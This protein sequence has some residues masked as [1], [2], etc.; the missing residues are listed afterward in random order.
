M[1]SECVATTRTGARHHDLQAVNVWLPQEQMP[2]TT[3]RKLLDTGAS[4]VA[5]RSRQGMTAS[6]QRSRVP[7]AKLNGGKREPAAFGA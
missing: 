5:A 3:I 1:E 7:R 4:G 6:V 2:V